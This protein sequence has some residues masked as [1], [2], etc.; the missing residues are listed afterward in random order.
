MRAVS[1]PDDLAAGDHLVLTY[2]PEQVDPPTQMLVVV[3][4][5]TRNAEGLLDFS[6]RPLGGSLDE[7]WTVFRQS[8]ESAS[9]LCVRVASVF[10]VRAGYAVEVGG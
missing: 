2:H 5:V 8:G 4:D 9:V 1:I 7:S 3:I 6:V 10:P